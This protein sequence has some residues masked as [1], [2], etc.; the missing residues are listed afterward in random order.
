MFITNRK[1]AQSVNNSKSLKF[2]LALSSLFFGSLFVFTPVH[3]DLNT[4]LVAYYPFNGNAND[5]SGYNNNGQIS[6]AVLSPDRSGVQNKAYY[7][8]GASQKI[9]VPDSLLLNFGTGDFSISSW[10]KSSQQGIWKRIVTKR[11]NPTNSYWYSLALV[12]NKALFET[13]DGN[14]I[15]SKEI[16]D[17]KWH[18]VTIARDSGNSEFQMYIDGV[19]D[20]SMIDTGQNLNTAV[21]TPLEIGVW[22]SESYDSGTFTG[23]ID[24]IRIYNRA[25]NASEIKDLYNVAESISGNIKGVQKYSA[26]CKNLKTGVSKKIALTDGAKEW[27]CTAAGLQSKKG[28]SVMVTIT[29][30]SQ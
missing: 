28:E 24:E 18:L 6:G 3:A 30:L 8:G 10:I 19:I 13:G 4:G 1:L 29:G 25:L 11:S 15:S 14:L 20:T 17:G 12:D 16:N 26:V 21:N 5:E 7:F 9:S 23:S 27:N 2:K 22:S